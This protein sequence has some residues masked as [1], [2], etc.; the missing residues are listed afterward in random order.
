[1]SIQNRIHLGIMGGAKCHA[2]YGWYCDLVT[3]WQEIVDFTM[4]LKHEIDFRL[5]L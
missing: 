5:E 3:G 4:Y 1:M 2:T